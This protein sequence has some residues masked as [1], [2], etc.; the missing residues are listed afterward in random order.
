MGCKFV[1]EPP[2]RKQRGIKIK[3]N[4]KSE[5]PKGRGIGPGEIN[6]NRSE[7]SANSELDGFSRRFCILIPHRP[8]KLLLAP[9]ALKPV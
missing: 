2:R 4:C 3:D 7:W 9:T 5:R 1:N 8:T 6:A